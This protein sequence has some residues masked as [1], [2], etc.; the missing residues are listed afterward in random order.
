MAEQFPQEYAD[1]LLPYVV[2]EEQIEKVQ[3]LILSRRPWR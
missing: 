2:V 1:L 3:P